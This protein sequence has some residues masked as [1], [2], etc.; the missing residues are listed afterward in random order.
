MTRYRIIQGAIALAALLLVGGLA[1]TYKEDAIPIT[2][3]VDGA[4]RQI[5]THQ[6][7]VGALLLDVGLTLRPEDILEPASETPLRP[8]MTVKVSRARPVT[9]QADGRTWTVWTHAATADRIL[10]ENDI[11]LH[12]AD[13]VTISSCDSV[14]D[15]P[16]C[17]GEWLV[18]VT[19][20]VPVF[21]H[22]NGRTFSF[23]TAASTVGQAL[24]GIG[25]ALYRADRIRPD[26]GQPV[27]AGM[28]IY[29]ERSR[30]VTVLVDGKTIR[31]RTHRGGV[32][33]V[34]ADLGIVLVGQDYTNPPP[35]T[36]LGE[37]TVVQVVRVAEAFV[38]QQEPI[39]Y[40]V[41]WQPDPE[42]EIDHRR[43]LQE[44]VA[45]VL[46]RRWRVR[47]ENGAEVARTLEDEYVAVPP[48]EKIIG[49]GTKIIVRQ[50]ETPEGTVEYWRVIRMLAT[51][52]S[53]STAGVPKNA[54][55]YGRTRLGLPMQKGIVAVDPRIIPLRSRVYVPGYGI[56]LA[57]D[58]GGAI[59][60]RRIDLGYDDDNLVLWYRWV[61]VYILT[62]VPPP[63]Q[64]PYILD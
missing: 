7:T 43:L 57:G 52:Y 62:P 32:G 18:Q 56:G 10:A 26:L 2:L 29:L 55:Y 49:Y 28:H 35:D 15:V 3:V 14:A 30:P 58:T 8:G 48:T 60:G 41:R 45:G 4:A 11:S 19:R 38:V 51:S 9:I 1:A 6:Q 23:D 24:E 39:P 46:Q 53:A 20:A 21:L 36:P 59:K 31:T 33:E 54:Y 27:S 5:R 44:G 13:R 42:L 17:S 64:I 37:E 16:A 22:E 61:D 63:D 25:L 47:Y 12:P 50:L 40:S 34:L